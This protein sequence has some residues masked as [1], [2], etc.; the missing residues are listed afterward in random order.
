MKMVFSLWFIMRLLRMICQ[1]NYKM[2]ENMPKNG[3]HF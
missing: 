1:R 3:V 2:P